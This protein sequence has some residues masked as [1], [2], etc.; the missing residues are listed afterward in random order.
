[1][2]TSLETSPVEEPIR[3]Y[4]EFFSRLRSRRARFGSLG[5]AT[6]YGGI[7]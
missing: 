7:V 5:P 3:K 4:L 6:M 2:K 1:M